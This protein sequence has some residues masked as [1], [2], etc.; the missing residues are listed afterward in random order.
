MVYTLETT[1]IKINLVIY[2]ANN[3]NIL[4]LMIGFKIISN[5]HYKFNSYIKHY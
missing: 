1:L 5:R 3:N 4:S 2:M